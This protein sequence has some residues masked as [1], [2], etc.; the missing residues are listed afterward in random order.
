M[1]WR[2]RRTRAT[3]APWRCRAVEE[4]HCGGGGARRRGTTPPYRIRREM[5]YQAHMKDRLS[6]SYS[7][8][9]PWRALAVELPRPLESSS[10]S[11]SLESYNSS[12]P[13][14]PYQLIVVFRREREE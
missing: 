10:N 13:S 14:R 11:S 1:P 5:R 4:T 8:S 2:R 12:D 3:A 7:S 9:D 6:E